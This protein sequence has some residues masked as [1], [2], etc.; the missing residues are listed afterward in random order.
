M[1]SN[2]KIGTRLGL[3]FGLMLV[4]L[5]LSAGIGAVQMNGIAANTEDIVTRYNFQLARAN[6]MSAQAYLISR[7]TRTMLLMDNLADRKANLDR[8][9]QSREVYKAAQSALEATLRTEEAKQLV[10]TIKD[11]LAKNRDANNKLITA[12]LAGRDK[13]AS[14]ILFGEARPAEQA[15][16]ASI[17]KA[18]K[19]FDAAIA[20]RYAEA[21][22]SHT[23]AL[24]FTVLLAAPWRCW[25]DSPWPSPSPV[26][27]P[28][29]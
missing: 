14:S 13:E 27:S 17:E 10:A 7:L 28:D 20:Q 23:S 15:V 2:F 16:Q 5:L 24:R 29:P 12:S 19:F 8:I 9:N 11:N 22:A 26:A 3:A 25:R 1:L 18:V 4:L 6:D 21:Q